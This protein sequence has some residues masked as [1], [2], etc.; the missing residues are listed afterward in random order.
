MLAVLQL[1]E[2]LASSGAGPASNSDQVS[3]SSIDG[4]ILNSRSERRTILACSEIKAV[5]V[6]GDLN[7]IP[8][9]PAVDND[10]SVER[11][12]IAGSDIQQSRVVC[13]VGV[14]NIVVHS[15]EE[16]AY[17]LSVI[18][19]ICTGRRTKGIQTI[20]PENSRDGVNTFV[21]RRNARY[22]IEEQFSGSVDSVV[23]TSHANVVNIVC[24][25]GEFH[26]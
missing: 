23:N 11:D 6:T 12:D 2:S 24:R 8:A 14:P 20:E 15:T 16:S 21:T 25:N 9:I 18:E 22:E 5:A 7:E 19:R 26:L 3:I 13:G 17:T 10:V 1:H 4:D